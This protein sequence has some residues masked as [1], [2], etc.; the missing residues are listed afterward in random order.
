[1]N[2]NACSTSPTAVGGTTTSPSPADPKL[3]DAPLQKKE[4]QCLLCL[5]PVKDYNPHKIIK[6]T[7]RSTSQRMFEYICS[8][9]DIEVTD[10]YLTRGDNRS[11]DKG[12]R[13]AKL[14]SGNIPLCEKCGDSY[15]G[16]LYKG[17][18]T[19]ED[20]V[21]NLSEK[22]S[23]Y[24]TKV[25]AV[26]ASSGGG[27]V[28]N[29]QDEHEM[30][31]SVRKIREKVLEKNVMAI[32]ENCQDKTM[33]GTGTDPPAFSN[34]EPVVVVENMASKQA[35]E[36]VEI[37]SSSSNESDSESGD[38]EENDE[39]SWRETHNSNYSYVVTKPA[40]GVI[41]IIPTNPLDAGTSMRPPIIKSTPAQGSVSQAKKRAMPPQFAIIETF[42]GNA[43]KV[44]QKR[45]RVINKRR[46]RE[47][48]IRMRICKF[49]NLTLPSAAALLKH[50]VN[51]HG[52]AKPEK[53]QQCSYS[54][55][56]KANLRS[57]M[58]THMD[59]ADRIKL[60]SFPCNECGAKFQRNSKLLA[61]VARSHR[62]EKPYICDLCGKN[63]ACKE[64]M[65][66]CQDK[67]KGITHHQCPYCDKRTLRKE[68]MKIH[69]RTH[70]GEKPFRCSHSQ[71]D[72][73]FA[74]RAALRVHLK[75]HDK[76]K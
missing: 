12:K 14:N 52:T 68:V 64:S 42:D 7:L 31:S 61:H 43:Q 34:N 67:H 59:E 1:M 55:L 46:A 33:K 69:L 30:M 2:S 44:E 9:L 19:Y 8:F 48:Q 49:C 75:V 53:C 40:P 10:Y 57:H 66:L 38:E 23:K 60:K 56:T 21:A 37:G 47:D 3:S 36:L 25:I 73:R 18:E 13:K 45:I 16:D 62:N 29:E 28:A 24:V 63:F 5:A 51:E 20:I 4:L 76:Y 35:P 6:K 32:A 70:T 50:E 11:R 27:T 26:S 22:I 17:F 39:E 54:C 71:C 65:K 58:E 41:H 15:Y 72:K 74:Q